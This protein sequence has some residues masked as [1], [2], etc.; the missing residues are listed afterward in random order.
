MQSLPNY[1]HAPQRR[2]LKPA[3]PYNRRQDRNTQTRHMMNLARPLNNNTDE[4]G[5]FMAALVGFLRRHGYLPG[6]ENGYQPANDSAVIFYRLGRTDERL[7]LRRDV[8]PWTITM[9]T[10]DEQG[11]WHSTGEGQ[12]VRDFVV[13]LQTLTNNTNSGEAADTIWPMFGNALNDALQKSYGWTARLDHT[14]DDGA[15]QIIHIGSEATGVQ[16]RLTLAIKGAKEGDA[17]LE[18]LSHGEPSEWLPLDQA[19]VPSLLRAKDSATAV[20]QFLRLA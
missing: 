20:A 17:T 11:I 5:Q 2:A 16:C 15:E 7:S 3:R 12:A 19:R 9:A 14:S 1:F 4:T 6:T 18:M 8:E 10:R 13:E